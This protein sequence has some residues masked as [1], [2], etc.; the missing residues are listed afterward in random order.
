MKERLI[1]AAGSKCS[2]ME[3]LASE[4]KLCDS[5]NLDIWRWRNNLGRE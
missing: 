1:P 3:K 4:L 5:W 2:F